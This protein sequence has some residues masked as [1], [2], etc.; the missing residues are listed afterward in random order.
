MNYEQL[1]SEMISSS[2]KWCE[3]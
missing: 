2:T 3:S 1:A